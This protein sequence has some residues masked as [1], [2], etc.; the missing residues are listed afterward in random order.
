MLKGNPKDYN[1]SNK[2]QD[3]V[4]NHH[5]DANQWP[6]F[7]PARLNAARCAYNAHKEDVVRED[8]LNSLDD[9]NY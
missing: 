8:G 5:D 4:E 3:V 9:Q 1:A 6:N 2:A 7:L